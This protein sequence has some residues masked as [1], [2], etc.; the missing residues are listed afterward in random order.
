MKRNRA[1][2]SK[3]LPPRLPLFS[4]A[5]LWLLL[6]R[7]SLDGFWLGAIWAIWGLYVLLVLV[8][9]WLYEPVDVVAVLSKKE[10]AS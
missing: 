4:T 9:I 2:A 10:A 7:L 6:D 1:I 5:V 3:N 8:A